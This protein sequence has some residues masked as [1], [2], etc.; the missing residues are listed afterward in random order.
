MI[1]SD[2][3]KQAYDLLKPVLGARVSV[4]KEHRM[5]YSRDWSPRHDKDNDIPDIVAV[6]RTTEECQEVVKV[7]NKLEIPVY[8]FAGGTG[9]GGGVQA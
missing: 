3:L 7:A 9:M 6:P 2:K 8:S 4:A 1:S 5:S